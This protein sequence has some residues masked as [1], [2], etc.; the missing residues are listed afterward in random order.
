MIEINYIVVLEREMLVKKI[1]KEFLN[2]FVF[3]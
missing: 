3:I 2:Y 1:V